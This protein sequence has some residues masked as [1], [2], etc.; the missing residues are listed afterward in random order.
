MWK[1]MKIRTCLRGFSTKNLTAP[2]RDTLHLGNMENTFQWYGYMV[3]NY[4]SNVY[5]WHGISFSNASMRMT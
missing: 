3:W 1:N 2:M 5:R 4:P